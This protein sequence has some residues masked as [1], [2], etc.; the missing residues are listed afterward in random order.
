MPKKSNRNAQ[1]GG[2]IRKRKDGTWEARYTIGRD[3]GTGKQIQKSVYGKTQAEVRKKL[4]AACISIDE[5]IYMEPS[6]MTFGSWLDIWINEYV[7]DIKPLTLKSYQSHINN[8][9]KP[10]L[11]AVKLS[12]LCTHEIQKLYNDVYKGS[13]DKKA[14]S[15]KT[16]LNLHG[17]VHKA[18]TQAIEIGY[19]KFNP[20]DACKLPRIEKPKINPLEDYEI[21]AFLQAI[22]GHKY[23]RIYLVDI[24]TGMRQAEIIG[25]TWDC[26]DFENGTIYIY[27]QLQKIKG[28]YKFGS[29][30]NDKTRT[31]T[32]A[33]SVMKVLQEQKKTQTEWHIKAGQAWD[34]KDNLVFTNEIGG[35]LAH[36]TVY[37]HFKLLVKSIGLSETRFHDL[38]HTYAVASLQSGDDIKTV[39]ENLGHHTAAFTLNVYGHVSERMKKDSAQRMEG[40]I[41]GVSNL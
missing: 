19:I 21:T 25:L 26:I 13:D 15:P 20:A 16:I 24:F 28:I 1:G 11:G 10:A 41:K 30:K 17:V 33:P 23:E 14:L 2:S 3:P 40:F 6:K 5:G 31:I 9:I 18:L 27:Q 39:Q 34:N 7:G 36:F 38:R 37:K 4:Q 32:P 29:L 35:H 22:K 8:H 12:A